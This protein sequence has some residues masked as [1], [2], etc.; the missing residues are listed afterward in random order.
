[1]KLLEN[2]NN[3][4]CQEIGSYNC[5]LPTGSSSSNRHGQWRNTSFML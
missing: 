2:T 3:Y 4:I 5:V 1:M